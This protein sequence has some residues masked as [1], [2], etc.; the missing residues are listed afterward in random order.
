MTPRPSRVRAALTG[1][2]LLAASLAVPAAAAQSAAPSLT[3][4]VSTKASR[5]VQDPGT[6]PWQKVPRDRVASECGLDPDLLEQATRLTPHTPFTVVRFGKLCWTGGYPSGTTTPYSVNSVTKTFAG[7]LFGMV[8]ARSSLDDTD[9]VS[10]WVPRDEME[11]KGINPKATL[12][13]VLA[14]TS[15][16]SDL[17]TGKKGAWSYDLGTREI[18][19]LLT[20]MNRAITLEPAKFPGVRN[21]KEF[22]AKELLAPLGMK[23]SSW[24]GTNIGTSL[25][26]TPEDMARLGQLLLRKGTWQNRQLIPERWVYQMTHAAYE[27]TNT[28]YGYLTYSNALSGWT[29]STG[30]NDEVCSPFTRWAGYPHAPSFENKDDLGGFPFARQK[31]DIGLTWAAGAGGQRIAVQRGLDLVTTVRDD[32]LSTEPDDPGTFEGHKRIWNKV[33]RPA[34]VAKDPVFKGDE[35]RFCEAYRSSSYAPSLVSPWSTSASGPT[36]R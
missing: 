20:A 11:E 6:G 30:T 34:L 33:V 19:V 29:Y 26:S 10:A 35:K 18:P 27:D 22:A 31:H 32:A 28:G 9:P 23:D 2:G 16:K 5:V 15:T 14:M 3:P 12:A 24:E 17:R 7:M 25:Q 36:A 4:G 1:C 21:M 8:A 13:H